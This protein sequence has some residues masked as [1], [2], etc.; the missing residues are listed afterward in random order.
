MRAL[1]VREPAP[2]PR[3]AAGRRCGGARAELAFGTV[4][5]HS[6]RSPGP[7]RAIGGRP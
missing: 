5:E 6:T 1:A 4:P 2:D 7:S 3:E